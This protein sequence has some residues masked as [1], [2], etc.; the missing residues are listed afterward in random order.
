M[1]E[2]WVAMLDSEE[3][4]LAGFALRVD[5]RGLEHGQVN[6]QGGVRQWEEFTEWPDASFGC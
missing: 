6:Y 1:G 2:V 3:S 4:Q 5:L